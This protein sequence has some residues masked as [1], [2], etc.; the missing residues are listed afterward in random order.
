MTSRHRSGITAGLF[1]L[2]FLMTAFVDAQEAEVY[3]SRQHN[4]TFRPP[5]GWTT[6]IIVQYAGEERADGTRPTLNL[7]ADNTHIDLS[8]QR[9]STLTRELLQEFGE[10]RLVNSRRTSIGAREAFQVEVAFLQA[11]VPMRMRQV[12]IPVAEQN[13]TYLFTFADSAEHYDETV[14]AAAGAMSSFELPR[15]SQESS[16]VA[17]GGPGAAKTALLILAGIFAIALV[18]GASYML[19]QRQRAT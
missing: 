17:R 19:I 14:S 13:R 7:T 6:D 4:V 3:N 2:F 9:L 8:E 11:G 18:V 12:Y 1:C 15:A 10:A 16:E 5:R